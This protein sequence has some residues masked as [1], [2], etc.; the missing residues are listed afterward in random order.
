[1]LFHFRAR[2]RQPVD[3]RRA[4]DCPSCHH[5][6]LPSR[7]WWYCQGAPVSGRRAPFTLLR[8][9]DSGTSLTM[10]T[11]VEFTSDAFPPY[12]GEEDTINPGIWG[13]RLAEFIVSQL[14]DHGVLTGDFHSEDWGWEIPVRNEAFPIFIRCGNQTDSR[15]NRFLCSID[16]SK[17]EVRKGLFKKV[18]TLKDVERVAA[19][20]DKVL[21]SHP[22]I[23]DLQW[24]DEND[25]TGP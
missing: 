20:L 21:K 2:R 3:G 11:S 4:E 14:P 1:M 13:K 7:P 10:Q 12:P 5:R 9:L 17:P 8:R 22:A 19:A 6:L 18:S 23:R 15:G 24:R 25:G 16:P